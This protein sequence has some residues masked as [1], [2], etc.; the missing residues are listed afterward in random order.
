MYCKKCNVH[1]KTN[2]LECPLC[3]KTLI[4]D[5]IKTI[6]SYPNMKNYRIRREMMKKICNFICLFSSI[7]CAIINAVTYDGTLWSLI[8]ITSSLF[9]LLCLSFM[10][11]PGFNA[12]KYVLYMSFGIPI[13]LIL[14]EMFEGRN[15]IKI[16]TWSINYTLPLIMAFGLLVMMILMMCSRKLFADCI[17]YFFILCIANSLMMFRFNHTNVTWPILLCILMVVFVLCFVIFFYGNRLKEEIQKKFH[18]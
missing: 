9:A 4:E 1:V 12:G 15:N 11:K 7:V 6:E 10:F 8:V 16:P 2:T 14:I 18:Y 3:K 5:E 17:T 13:L